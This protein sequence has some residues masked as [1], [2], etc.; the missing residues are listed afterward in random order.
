[1]SKNTK[2]QQ[3]DGLENV[4]ETLNKAELFIDNNKSVISYT[5]IGILAVVAIFFAFQRFY[6]VPKNNEAS[7]AMFGA[8]QY[9]QRDSFDVALNGDGNY[10]GF[11]DVIDDYSITQTA[12]LAHYY[13]GLCYMY[14]GD[15]E[16]AI[17]HL[18]KFKSKDI[19][20][21]VVA[22]GVIG[23]AYV[24][25]GDE[26]KG[27]SYYEKAA[28]NVNNEFTSPLYLNK[29]AQVYEKLGN[30]KKALALYTAIKDKYAMSQEAMQADKNIEKMNAEIAK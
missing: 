6:L 10:A 14:T 22:L 3:P 2:E 15:Y 1:M 11:L 17:S 5:V 27:A 19:T 29:A 20:L 24:E 18:K 23:D 25:L 7:A 30:Y 13:A 9:F 8:E 21:S 26:A 28:T 4:Q 12:K 16:S